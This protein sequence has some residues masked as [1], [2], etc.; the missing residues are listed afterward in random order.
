MAVDQMESTNPGFIGQLKGTLTTLRY[1]YTTIFVD[2][3]SDYTYIYLHAKLTSEETVKAK[4][5]FETHAK[6]Y[7][8]TIQ[9]YHADNGRFQDTSFKNACKEQGQELSFCGVNAHF[10]NGRAERKIRDLQD[11]ART[12]LLHVNNEPVVQ[13]GH[14]TN[15][16]WSGR[17]R[18]Q[19]QRFEDYMPHE[20]IAFETLTYPIEQE[21]YSHPI[22]AM[23]S[24]SD[25][26]TMYLWKAQKEEDF[27]QFQA[28]MQKE[29]D[30]H[31]SRGN[32]KLVPRKDL[33]KG[34]TVLPSVWAMK[35]K[36][37]IS[38]R[39]IYKWKARINIDVSKQVKGVHYEQTYSPVVAWSTTR[40]FLIQSL[41]QKWHT[42]QLDFV[43]AFPQAKVERDLYMD[44]PKGVQLQGADRSKYVLQLVKN[45]YGQKQAGRV[46]Y[47]HLVRGLQEIGFT[48][49]KVDECVFY[50][51]QSVLLIYV[52]DSILMG[53]NAAE[54]EYLVKQMSKRFEIQEEG[55]LGDF[56][57]I[58]IAREP[59]GN[60]T[61]TQ[62][63]LI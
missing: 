8:V 29:I 52:D 10:Q 55:S 48:R 57:G 19:P 20:Q 17:I 61:L 28:A 6:T 44:I 35:R 1:R 43:L 16:Q 3:Y 4:V 39:E 42:K 45:L 11:R 54:L 49:S 25:P 9:Q 51:K 59:D 24:T 46:W 38:T 47:Q 60:L 56:L 21:D 62:P 63:Q 37:R 31:T 53:P 13:Q 32:W 7:G 36:R 26:D 40:F 23:K 58:Q 27:P 41:L 30:D 18:R 15:T 12:S 22:T 34:A 50:Y 33:P 14:R 2:M 5:A